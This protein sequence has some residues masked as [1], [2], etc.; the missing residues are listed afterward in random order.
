MYVLDHLVN[1]CIIWNGV[2]LFWRGF[3]GLG[4]N[5]FFPDDLEKSCWMSLGVGFG[6][7]LVNIPLQIL[8]NMLYRWTL[9]KGLHVAFRVVLEDI[10]ILIANFGVVHHW[11]GVWLLQDVY[12]LPDHENPSVSCGISHVAGYVGLSLLLISMSNVTVGSYTTGSASPKAGCFLA[13]YYF[14]YFLSTAPVD[15]EVSPKVIGVPN[16]TNRNNTEKLLTS[17]NSF[18]AAVDC[19][20]DIRQLQG[21]FPQDQCIIGSPESLPCLA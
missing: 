6:I 3:W 14:R 5:H 9:K 15:N 4:D 21:S 7:L 12:F 17:P 13:N 16:G 11:R 2:V 19:K 20:L 1:V 18:P 10:L 8:G